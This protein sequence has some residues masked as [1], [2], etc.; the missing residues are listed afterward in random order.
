MRRP[1]PR[2]QECPWHVKLWRLRHILRV[3][4]DAMEIWWLNYGIIPLRQA[5]DIAVGDAHSRMNWLY[6]WD[7]VFPEEKPHAKLVQQ[8]ID[9]E[10]P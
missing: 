8:S 10:R 2:F 3:P 7:E 6:N 9:S 4:E 5:W 1:T